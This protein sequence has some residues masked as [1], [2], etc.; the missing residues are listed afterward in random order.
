MRKSLFV[1]AITALTGTL[2]FFSRGIT[3]DNSQWLPPGD[4]VEM[5]KQY[6]REHFNQRE[7]LI[8]AI[9]LRESFFAPEVLHAL[10]QLEGDI[11]ERIEV[12]SMAH[13]LSISFLLRDQKTGSLNMT[14]LQKQFIQDEMSLRELRQHFAQSY[15]HGRY[16]DEKMHSFL[17]VIRPHLSASGEER[18]RVRA[19]LNTVIANLLQS[20]PL[21][22]QFKMA[23]EAKI[24]HEL[25]VQ[26]V[27]ALQGLIPVIFGFI[28]FFLGLYYANLKV[29][30]IVVFSAII[31]LLGSLATFRLLD[32][33]LNI[34]TSIAPL[35]IMAIAISD[36]IHIMG[37]YQ[38]L[39]RSSRT[40]DFKK[41]MGI[42]W[43]P[44]LVTSLTTGI[45]FFSLF[46]SQ[47]VTLKQLSFVAPFSILLAYLL[48]LGSNWSLLYLLA[49]RFSTRVLAGRL[50]W[51]NF[52][53][54]MAKLWGGLAF[55]VLAGV[56][57]FRWAYT[58]TNLLDAF[59][60]Q[61]SQ[62]QRDFHYVDTH[63]GGTGAFD[64][65]INRAQ[66][67]VD[68]KNIATYESF[69]DLEKDL[70][71]LQ[72]LER[73]E[74][75]LMPVRMVHEKLAETSG[76]PAS[77]EALSQELLFLEFS[78]SAES[79]DVLRP[80]LNFEGSVGRIVL[81]TPNL[82]NI[83][84]GEFKEAL[85][86]KLEKLPW[87][88]ELGGNNEYFLRLSQ[89]L[90]ET[91]VSS[92]SGTLLAILILMACFYHLRVSWMAVLANLLPVA[93]V[94]LTI[95]LLGIP[96]DFATVL[97]AAICLGLSVDNSIHLIHHLTRGGVASRDLLEASL[98]PIAVVTVVFLGVFALFA[99]SHLVLLQRFGLFSALMMATAFFTNAWLIPPLVARF[100]GQFRFTQFPK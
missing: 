62:I 55:L 36:S 12:E 77:S 22:S 9:Q 87:E 1:A 92:L 37:Y 29:I 44:C 82:S 18:R 61:S 28:I 65:L 5:A 75:Y 20:H 76:D 49:P 66:R 46:F 85:G 25:D 48:I 33:P 96:F 47:L 15:Y 63:H 24:N 21:F 67:G 79:E 95:V 34:L 11:K 84:A 38:Q 72:N 78:Q 90:L 30:A 32:V 98:R 17:L 60:K 51:A 99:T 94:M 40:V 71:T 43:K 35:L 74:S 54:P 42:T 41:L 100:S 19:Q 6:T 53:K 88:V 58:E 81:R 50:S 69:V 89:V 7:E 27:K 97:I 68:Y 57:V 86:K 2:A 14:T 13:P 64:L 56:V 73:M 59:F 80:F 23:G 45:G 10:I 8:V 26:N 39:Q 91:Q 52:E 16:L 93:V 70:I 3:F 83:Q 4:P 31:T